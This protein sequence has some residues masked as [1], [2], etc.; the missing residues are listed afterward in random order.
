[1]SIETLR[2][3]VATLERPATRRRRLTS[4]CQQRPQRPQRQP[5][6]E[7]YRAHKPPTLAL[8]TRPN[9]ILDAHDR[10]EHRVLQAPQQ[11]VDADDVAHEQGEEA[12]VREL[13]VRR[14]VA[15]ERVCQPHVQASARGT[16]PETTSSSRSPIALPFGQHSSSSSSYAGRSCLPR[17]RAS[18]IV[19]VGARPRACLPRA[20]PRKFWR[21]GR[22]CAV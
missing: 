15:V 21:G 14:A 7:E 17:W 22:K 6:H 16:L 8:A 13:R 9:L 11:P 3:G 10:R 2:A 19:P 12:G 5:L 4:S 18:A 20:P 1:M